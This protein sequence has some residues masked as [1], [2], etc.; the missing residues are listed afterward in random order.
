MNI[1]DFFKAFEPDAN[2][3][4][5]LDKLTTALGAAAEMLFIFFNSL[6]NAGFDHEESLTLTVEY[7]KAVFGK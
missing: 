2:P 3:T 4:S 1:N 7:M 5:E 6:E